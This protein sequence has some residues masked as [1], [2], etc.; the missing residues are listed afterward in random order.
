M[1]MLETTDLF[2]G[3]F[4]LCK[5]GRLAGI[6]I[7]FDGRKTA[8]FQISG[9]NL[10]LLNEDYVTGNALV[11]PVQLKNSLNHLRDILFNK[12]RDKENQRYDNTKHQNKRTNRTNSR[13]L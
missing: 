13:N 10:D 12:L 11:D 4:L 1:N 5:G 3:A 7:E 8:T 9:E 2:K 6:R